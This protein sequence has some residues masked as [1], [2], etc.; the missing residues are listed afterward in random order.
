ML[1]PLSSENNVLSPPS[2]R[3]KKVLPPGNAQSV[4]KAY[5]AAFLSETVS[6][7]PGFACSTAVSRSNGMKSKL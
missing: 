5:I 4:P 3:K 7:N 1:P 6:L 2:S